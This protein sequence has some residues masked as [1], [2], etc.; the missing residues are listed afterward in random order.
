MFFKR[1][2]NEKV[3]CKERLLINLNRRKMSFVGHILRS[4]NTSY[5]LFMG[6]VMETEAEAD[7]KHSDTLKIQGKIWWYKFCI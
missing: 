4:K 7:Q 2:I 6:S 1:L 3:H 5:D